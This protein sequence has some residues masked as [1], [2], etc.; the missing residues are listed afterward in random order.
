MSR[1]VVGTKLKNKLG[2]TMAAEFVI[3]GVYEVVGYD[4]EGDYIVSC[5]RS[6]ANEQITYFFREDLLRHFDVVEET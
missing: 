3:G 4:D 2:A 5:E 6:I 1:I